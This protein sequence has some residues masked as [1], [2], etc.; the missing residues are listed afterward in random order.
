MAK[1][2]GYGITITFIVAITLVLAPKTD[3]ISRYTRFSDTDLHF[4]VFI[5]VAN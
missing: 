3:A 5:K 1:S 2:I 4:F